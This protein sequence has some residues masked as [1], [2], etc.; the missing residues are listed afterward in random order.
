MP[1]R[2]PD[3]AQLN[4][5]NPSKNNLTTYSCVSF[6]GLQQVFHTIS[7]R[8]ALDLLCTSGDP[9]CLCGLQIVV[10]ADPA[11][12]NALILKEHTNKIPPENITCL[13]RL[14]HNR[15]TAQVRS[16]TSLNIHSTCFPVCPF[17]C[18]TIGLEP[19]KL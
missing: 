6:H 11:N 2:N 15:A 5:L 4:E 14:D 13:T 8:L 7:A 10:V 16:L 17:Y 12:T 3:N 19:M 9:L 1:D 18:M